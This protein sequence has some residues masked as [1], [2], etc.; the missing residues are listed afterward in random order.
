MKFDD[1]KISKSRNGQMSHKLLEMNELYE[2]SVCRVSVG[3][4]HEDDILPANYQTSFLIPSPLVGDFF[5]SFLYNLRWQEKQEWRRHESLRTIH[6]HK[7]TS[8]KHSVARKLKN[9]R[10][11]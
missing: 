8:L 7:N 5:P 4:N 3:F 2:K 1:E 11:T 6:I 10:A 9:N